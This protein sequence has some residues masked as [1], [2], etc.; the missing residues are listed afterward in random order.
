MEFDFRM[1]EEA[2]DECKGSGPRNKLELEPTK[3]G[4]VRAKGGG[5]G[6][7]VKKDRAD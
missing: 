2:E 4:G 1:T 3:E 6:S 5:R 7:R